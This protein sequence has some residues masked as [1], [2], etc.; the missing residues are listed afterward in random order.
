MHLGVDAFISY[1]HAADARLAPALEH[2]LERLARP[3]NRLR[4]VSV[5]RDQTDLSLTPHLWSTIR[6]ALDEARWFVLLA[7]PESAAS[8]YV[9]REVAHFVG[10]AG[11]ERVLVVLTGGEL[12]WDRSAGDFA[13]ASTAVPPALRGRFADEPLWLDLRWARD[14]D[15]LSLRLSRFRA[16]VSQVAAPIR[17]LAPDELEGEDVRLHRRAR[18][19]AQGAVAA[20]AA[21]A[22][23][24]ASAAVVAVSNARRADA[25]ARQAVGRQVGLA[26]LDVPA[27]DLDRAF[28]MALAAADLDPDGPARF[29]P[30]RVLVGRNARLEALLH[31]PSPSAP[32]TGAVSS[33]RAVALPGPDGARE[34]AAAWR[35]DGGTDVVSWP[36]GG[37]PP[38]TRRVPPGPDPTALTA[39]PGGGVVLGA[40]GGP[41]VVVAPDG[42]SRPLG[43]RLLALAP[44]VSRALVIDGAGR[45]AVVRLPDG[46]PVGGALPDPADLGAVGEGRAAVAGRG[47]VRLVDLRSG[48]VAAT[49]VVGGAAAV[50]VLP[51][52][53]P[54]VVTVSAGGDVVVLGVAGNRLE[55]RRRVRLPEGIGTARSVLVAAD[56]GRAL[57]LGTTGTVLVDLAAS[58]SA[59]SARADGSDSSAG[60]DGSDGSAGTVD[61]GEPGLAVADPTGRYVAVGGRRLAV[62]DLGSGAR[63]LAVPV[64]VGAIA[65]SAGCDAATG[66]CRVV[67]AGESLDVWDPRSGRRIPLSDQTNAQAVAIT[68]DAARVATAGWGG[69]AALWTLSEAGSPGTAL[70]PGD[71]AAPVATAPVAT[72]PAGTAPVA[73]APVATAPVATAPAGDARVRP[74]LRVAGGSRLLDPASPVRLWD[75]ATGADIG[76]DARCA[77]DLVAVSPGTRLLAGYRRADAVTTLCRLDTGAVV[78]RV[79]LAGGTA[80]ATAVAVDDDGSVVLGGNGTVERYPA[81][82]AGWRPGVGVDVRLGGARVDVR[83]LATRG[84]VVA[85]GLGTPSDR[86]G[87]PETGRAVVWDAGRAGTPVQFDVDQTDVPAVALLGTDSTLVAVAGRDAAD[88]PVTVQVWESSTRRRVGRGLAGLRG[89]VVALDGD[90][91]AVTGADGTGHVVRWALDADPGREV[92]AVVGRS[93]TR[94]EWASVAG[95]AL[96]PYPYSPVCPRPGTG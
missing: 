42:A 2:G 70:R 4:A 90:R 76:V 55:P 31:L 47:R 61:A 5:F 27:A 20:L 36:R 89:E 52:G 93:M 14:V 65:W 1:S 64:P 37:G 94:L 77:G 85:A 84:G 62:W 7:C 59:R 24:A 16:A 53:G 63:V 80:P 73:T 32:V 86:G 38:T 15:D 95:G 79:R 9:N 41:A 40:A 82:G 78:G 83:S 51:G 57:V 18:R 66:T 10:R 29:E 54:G 21:L 43:T 81:S 35:P 69:A 88:G 49:G 50:A 68:D 39:L 28:L 48:R 71:A 91:T 92:C 34:V 17:G 19:L 23:V 11:T 8:Q 56:G 96:A 25:E 67:T 87:P 44:K 74:V 22:V 46:A 72:A 60:S 58:G 6:S 33:V 45:P 12:A 75:R 13:T 3:W 26:A 30:A